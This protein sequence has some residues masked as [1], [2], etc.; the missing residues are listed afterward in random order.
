MY[1]CAS[2]T[3]F[4]SDPLLEASFLWSIL[5][6]LLACA[7]STIYPSLLF[8]WNQLIIIIA[9]FHVIHHL[10]TSHC[11]S[12]FA[13]NNKKDKK[14]VGLCISSYI[15]SIC[16][17]CKKKLTVYSRNR[18]ESS[19]RIVHF[20]SFSQDWFLILTPSIS[21][22]YWIWI[23]VGQDWSEELEGSCR[24]HFHPH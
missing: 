1:R 14:S 13:I 6:L 20:T 24:C 19:P 10:Y 7:S 16:D 11:N 4:W 22:S 3:T 18:M 23:R 2:E 15:I 17:I 21:G 9:N 5:C 12:L 8:I